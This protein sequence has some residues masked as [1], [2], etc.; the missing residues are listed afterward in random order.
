MRIQGIEPWSVPWEGTMIPLHQMRL[1]LTKSNNIFIVIKIFF[2][3]LSLTTPKSPLFPPQIFMFF[4]QLRPTVS[5]LSIR[6]RPTS[7][8]LP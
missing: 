3:L 2:V 7:P 4:N 1:L 5:L 6:F 8:K